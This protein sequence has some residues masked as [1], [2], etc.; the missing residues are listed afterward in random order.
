MS[1]NPGDVVILQDGQEV[2]VTVSSVPQFEAIGL[3]KYISFPD[4]YKAGE[5]EV[6]HCFCNKCGVFVFTAVNKERLVS[7]VL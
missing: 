3:S 6:Y 1:K 4:R 7:S 2:P 5:S